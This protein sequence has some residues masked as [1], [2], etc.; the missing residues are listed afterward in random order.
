VSRSAL[1][2]VLL[3]VVILAAAGLA[4]YGYRSSSEL[5]QFE[6][7]IMLGT[8][9]ELADE[10]VFGIE[11]EITRVENELY[12]A[13]DLDDLPAIQKL[14]DDRPL[15]VESV[16]ILAQD[17]AIVPGGFFT[18]SEREAA[19]FR[20]LFETRILPELTLGAAPL[21]NRFHVHTVIDGRPYLFGVQRRIEAG[22]MS[23]IVVDAD[24]AYLVGT[25]FPQFFD[26]RSPHLYQVVDENG[27][28][29]YGYSFA[30]V[31][32]DDVVERRFPETLTRW[33]LRVSQREAGSLASQ[34]QQQATLDLILIS[35]ALAVIVA[36]LGFMVWAMRRERRLNQLKSD[37]ISNV[38]HELKTPLSIIS[39]FGELLAMGRTRGAEQTAEYAEIIRRE[40][41]RLS[42]LIDNV[43]DFAKI[44]RGVE[45]Y[46]FA[47]DDLG[48][49][50][51]RA[52]EIS[53]HRLDSA[54]MELE[55]EIAEDLPTAE[56][57]ANALTLAVLNLVD[58]AIKYA[59]GGGKLIV[60]VDSDGRDLILDVRDHGPG[61]P[62]DEREQVFERFYRSRD[63]RLKPIRGSG[64]GLALV[65]HIAVAHGGSI[66]VSDNDPGCC[67]RL[68]IPA[69]KP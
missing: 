51:R 14:F 7:D 32:P 15:P 62:A 63:V 45:V 2:Y 21:T 1:V 69:S 38:S 26:V 33:R 4:F 65:H 36:G 49:I 29:V 58:N 3:P 30:G 46:E 20:R 56:I 22:R 42:R 52:L 48:E 24:L 6:R 35:M 5:A 19:E 43:L 40:S 54:Q 8:L 9:R 53:A 66:E 11:S 59:V 28:I 10:K 12:N 55:L 37:F 31:D 61:I 44:E 47:A 64:I 68:R 34:S 67:F 41:V 16:L 25:V 39:M 13:I 18:T 57:D 27:D 17:G 60:S 23:F 50:V